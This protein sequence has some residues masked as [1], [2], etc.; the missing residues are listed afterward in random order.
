[1][2]NTDN[3]QENLFQHSS[4]LATAQAEKIELL[5]NSQTVIH[6]V[7][8]M[9]QMMKMLQHLKK[10]PVSSPKIKTEKIADRSHSTAHTTETRNALL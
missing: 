3:K 2:S 7:Q 4:D 8:Q 1:M 6:V 9:E 10:S 5:E